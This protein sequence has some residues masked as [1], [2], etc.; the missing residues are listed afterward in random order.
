M[1]T[2]D[3][4][5]DKVRLPQLSREAPACEHKR[6]I[7]RRNRGLSMTNSKSAVAARAVIGSD[8][9][10]RATRPTVS[11]PHHDEPS[12][13]TAHWHSFEGGRTAS[14]RPYRPPNMRSRFRYIRCRDDPV[15]IR[16]CVRTNIHHA[17]CITHHQSLW[18]DG[19]QWHHEYAHTHP[20]PHQRC[21]WT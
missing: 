2:A 18:R 12:I 11:D 16:A 20:H 1:R 19:H 3:P 21:F 9:G 5:S 13:S 6:V 4:I 8:V 7:T 10:I 17:S 14:A 15:F